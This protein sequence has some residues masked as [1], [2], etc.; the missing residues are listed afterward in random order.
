[1]PRFDERSSLAHAL[2]LAALVGAWSLTERGAEAQIPVAPPGGQLAAAAQRTEVYL[3][4]EKSASAATRDAARTILAYLDQ[5]PPPG[6]TQVIVRSFAGEVSSSTVAAYTLAPPSPIDAAIQAATLGAPSRATIDLPRLIDDLES[7]ARGFSRPPVGPQRIFVIVLGDFA[8]APLNE[9]WR[10]E[11]AGARALASLRQTVVANQ[12]VQ[13]IAIQTPPAGAIPAGPYREVTTELAKSFLFFDDFASG[14]PEIAGLFSD[15]STPLLLQLSPRPNRNQVGFQI[16]NPSFSV[17]EPIVYRAR[18][19]AIAPTA[20]PTEGPTRLD[21]GTG[22]VGTIDLTVLQPFVPG[23]K[24]LNVWIEADGLDPATRQVV[25][26]GTAPQPILLGDCAQV[27]RAVYD[28]EPKRRGDPALIRWSGFKASSPAHRSFVGL[29][30]LGHLES[31][32]ATLAWDQVDAS[33]RTVRALGRR[34]ISKQAFNQSRTQEHAF[35]G[36]ER[37]ILAFGRPS[38]TEQRRLCLAGRDDE[39]AR[40]R[41]TL[42][43]GAAVLAEVVL[44]RK[45]RAPGDLVPKAPWALASGLL[46]LLFGLGTLLAYGLRAADFGRLSHAFVVLAVGA[47]AFF[48]GLQDGTSLGKALERLFVLRVEILSALGFATFVGGYFL[49]FLLGYFDRCPTPRE[50]LRRVVESRLSRRLAR[51]RWRDVGVVVL[52]ALL[53]LLTLSAVFLLRP[54]VEECRFEYVSEVAP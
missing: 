32:A 20:V 53:L 35:E 21:P 42:S 40:L 27:T 2:A 25:R 29:S 19:D 45:H 5:A 17:L 44:L 24:C 9:A 51:R 54:P 34:Q 52:L 18:G 47:L 41:V 4:V 33:G 7:A 14:L 43:A 12:N 6:A 39:P 8:H 31:E 23:G 30:L 37:E 3:Y 38:L 1:M 22:G 49:L 13:L 48:L 50:S 11:D 46:V 10:K 16:S 15:A 28:L 36:A 26:R